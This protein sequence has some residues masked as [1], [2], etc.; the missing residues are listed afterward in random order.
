MIGGNQ[1]DRLAER[2]AAEV[3]DRHLDRLDRRGAVDV[4]INTGHVVDVADHHL[5]GAGMGGARPQRG[6]KRSRNVR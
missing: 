6:E 4:G 2:G 3:G 5:V 1:F